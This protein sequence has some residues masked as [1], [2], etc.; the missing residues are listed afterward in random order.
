MKNKFA[1]YVSKFF[2]NYLH[3]QRGVSQETI[4]VYASS[5]SSC[6]AYLKTL[7]IKEKNIGFENLNKEN[8]LDYLTWLEENRKNSISTRN[9]R[10]AGLPSFCEYLITEEIEQFDN[11]SSILRIKMKKKVKKQLLHITMGDIK[12]LL[13]KPDIHTK[14]GMRDLAILS[15]LYDSGCR[16]SE[17]INIKV[18][19]LNFQK[20]TL[21]V[22]GKGKKQ[23]RIPVSKNVIKIVEKYIK[24]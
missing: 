1:E 8:V 7:G 3:K 6:I 16:I 2:T 15:L 19:N 24:E 9:L 11:C 5:L 12:L 18:S 17:F 22:L 13:S 23:R 10:L 21:D 4:K 14:K 20:C